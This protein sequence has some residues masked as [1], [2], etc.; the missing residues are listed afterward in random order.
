M[1][2]CDGYIHST[3]VM[4]CTRVFHR[5]TRSHGNSPVLHSFLIESRISYYKLYN[6]HNH[7]IE[8]LKFFTAFVPLYVTAGTGAGA[9][10]D[11]PCYPSLI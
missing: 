11:D 6:Q 3:L 9:E 5:L 2:V 7:W 1:R 4:F 10:P 8:T